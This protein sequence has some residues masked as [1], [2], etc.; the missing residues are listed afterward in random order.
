MGVFLNFDDDDYY[1][2]Y[3]YYD[4]CYYYDYYVMIWKRPILERWWKTRLSKHICWAYHLQFHLP[5]EAATAQG[6]ETKSSWLIPG[7]KSQLLALFV[8]LYWYDSK[9][10]AWVPSGKL[11]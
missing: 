5:G 11:T 1:D 9:P 8:W 10:V 7:C 2:Y 4:Y 6:L 3:D